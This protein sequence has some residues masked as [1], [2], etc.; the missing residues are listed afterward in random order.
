MTPWAEVRATGV[1]TSM[2]ARIARAREALKAE[3]ERA[4]WRRD[5]AF[6]ER[7]ERA[8]ERNRRPTRRAGRLGGADPAP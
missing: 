6:Q 4:D 1:R 8:L 2:E 3:R 7:F 5:R